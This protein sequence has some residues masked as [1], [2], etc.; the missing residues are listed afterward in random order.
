M[1]GN[2]W[3]LTVTILLL[4]AQSCQK[5][6]LNAIEFEKWMKSSKSLEMK[7]DMGEHAYTLRFIPEDWM[8]YSN[9]NKNYTAAEFESKKKDASDMY[10]FKLEIDIKSGQQNLLKNG[11]KNDDEYFQRLYYVSYLMKQDIAMRMGDITY[12]CKLYSYERAYDLNSKLSFMLGFE[13]PKLLTDDI[14]I[15]IRPQLFSDERVKF[16]LDKSV[17]NSIPK[18]VI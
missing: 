16:M 6:E 11:L 9:L 15:E 17:I 7:K 13:K 12:P 1:K 14:V 8:A 18:L 4:C 5:G 10:Y 2:S 3:F